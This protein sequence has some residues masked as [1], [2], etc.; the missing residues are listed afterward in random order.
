VR[1]EVVQQLLLDE[2]SQPGILVRA[3]VR[4]NLV[5][6]RRVPAADLVPLDGGPGQELLRRDPDR[7]GEAQGRPGLGQIQTIKEIGRVK[8]V[9][10]VLAQADGVGRHVFITHRLAANEGQADPIEQITIPGIRREEALVVPGEH[11]DADD[12]V[13]RAHDA[14]ALAPNGVHEV[15]QVDHLALGLQLKT[16]PR[17]AIPDGAGVLD[18]RGGDASQGPL[19]TDI[20]VGHGGSSM[21][22]FAGR[23]T[24]RPPG[25]SALRAAEAAPT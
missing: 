5:E 7:I 21:V 6:A 20:T 18:E 17:R 9:A 2:P 1:H 19:K 15:D 25:G 14:G 3:D 13:L 23:A 24:A 16:L 8:Q 4:R 22:L 12:D 10:P 11:I